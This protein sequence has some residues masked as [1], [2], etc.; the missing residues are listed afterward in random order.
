MKQATSRD[1]PKPGKKKQP[2]AQPDEE[3]RPLFRAQIL[4][5][6]ACNYFPA[7]D[8][9]VKELID[10]LIRVSHGDQD[11]AERIVNR[12]LQNSPNCPTPYGFEVVAS[13]V[14]RVTAPRGC[15][16]CEGTG[17]HYVTKLTRDPITGDSYEADCQ[18]R[19]DCELGRFLAA[20]EVERK[21]MERSA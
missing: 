6:A 7:L 13:E 1:I 17:F 11:H 12:A 21:Q 8:E 14:P 19:C 16:K 2:A 20:R 15:E 3:K 10:S 9:G 4:R 5:L 18:E